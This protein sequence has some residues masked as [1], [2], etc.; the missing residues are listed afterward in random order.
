MCA[1]MCMAISKDEDPCACI[2]TYVWMCWV[3]VQ[4]GMCVCVCARVCVH[5]LA[6]MHVPVDIYLR[7]GVSC[8]SIAPRMRQPRTTDSLPHGLS[9]QS[10]GPREPEGKS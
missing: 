3:S 10:P 2:Y 7:A 9:H 1:L 5:M 4:L 8:A 6:D